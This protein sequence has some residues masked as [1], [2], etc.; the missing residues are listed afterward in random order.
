V[1]QGRQQPAPQVLGQAEPLRG[2]G[3]RL[4]RPPGR[5]LLPPAAGEH[6]RGV[7]GIRGR[8]D[9]EAMADGDARLDEMVAR[10]RAEPEQSVA[11]L[12]ELIERPIPESHDADDRPWPGHYL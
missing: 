6:R 2:P 3:R 8:R 4:G 9:A 11:R 1:V 10:W 12:R 7:G 5:A